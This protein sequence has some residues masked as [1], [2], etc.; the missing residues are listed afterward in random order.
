MSIYRGVGGSVGATNDALVNEVNVAAQT[1]T[2]KAAEAAQSA[3][4]AATSANQ[5]A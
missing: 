3:T 1:A 5:A 4:D 2:S